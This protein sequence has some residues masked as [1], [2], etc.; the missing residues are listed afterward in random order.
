[1]AEVDK[2]TSVIVEQHLRNVVADIPCLI[3]CMPLVV[4]DQ[5]KRMRNR[6]VIE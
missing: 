4:P 6:V 5:H 2:G 3:V 1:M